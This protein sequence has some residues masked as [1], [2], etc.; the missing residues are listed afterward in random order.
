MAELSLEDKC[1]LAAKLVEQSP[2]GEINDVINDI[3]AIINDD[4]ALMPHVLPTLKAYNLAQLH[5][6]DHVAAEG[7]P[8][9]SSILSEANILPGTEGEKERYV[10]AEGKRSFVFDHITLAISDYQPYE[11][12][13]EE[14][15]FRSALSQSLTKYAKN[16]FPSGQ[17]SVS[18]SQYPLSPP[19]PPAP[20]STQA[21]GPASES[22]STTQLAEADSAAEETAEPVTDVITEQVNEGD[23]EPAPTPATGDVDVDKKDELVRPESLDQLDELVEEAKEEEEGVKTPK[24]GVR[25]DVAEV[26]ESGE[27]EK[28]LT[29]PTAVEDNVET[30]EQKEPVGGVAEERK[31][32]KIDNPLYTLEI[33][34][35]KYN[36]N[37]FWTGRWRTKWIVDKASG[38][39]NGDINVDVHYY[40]QGN[41][42]LATKHSAS[43]P[44]PTEE[45]GGQ[46]IASQIVTTIS[47]IETA[48]HLELNDV[49]GELGDKAFR[50]LRRA[51]PVTRQKMDWEKVTGYSLGSDLTKARA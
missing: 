44:L 11:I 8:A 50:A 46:S 19:A 18:C 21:S 48:Y 29:P 39:V 34:G 37:N 20:T 22:P 43:F 26:D 25:P 5:V 35:N 13:E 1:K 36:P 9:H 41:V 3:R 31:Q 27:E 38:Q 33:V 6:V 47:K 10:D 30:E 40:E 51:L 15:F 23:L 24:E 17:S 12:P 49:Y 4:E 2:P 42:Q 32:E 45:V 28:V 16:H 7:V 14:E